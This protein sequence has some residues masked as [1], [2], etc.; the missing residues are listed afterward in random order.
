MAITF[1]ILFT[2]RTVILPVISFSIL[3]VNQF[4]I[5]FASVIVFL[6]AFLKAIL[7]RY[8]L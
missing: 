5:L 8:T 4:A 1:T 2:T 6:S 7:Y 3:L